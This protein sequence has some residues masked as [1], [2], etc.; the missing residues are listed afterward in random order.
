MVETQPEHQDDTLGIR[1]KIA[2]TGAFTTVVLL[3]IAVTVGFWLMVAAARGSQLDLLNEQLD[4]FESRLAEED[5]LVVSRQGDSRIRVVKDGQ[6]IPPEQP[7][8]IR[9]VRASD[10]PGVDRVIGEVNTTRVDS[11]FAT[12]RVWLWIFVLVTSLIVGGIAWLVV[13]RALRPVKQLTKQAKNNL[14]S[15]TMDLV[16]TSGTGGEIA[17]LAHTFNTMF[18]QLRDADLERRRFVSDASH[19]LRTPL[20][21]L[22][23]DAEYALDHQ[24]EHL[25][26]ENANLAQS[27]IRQSD[28]LTELVDDL[29][30][31]AVLDEDQLSLPQA[32]VQAVLESAGLT[33]LA[34]PGQQVWSEIE[35]PDIART[36]ANVA[37]N[38]R[39]HG[40][41][42]VRLV[43]RS[44]PDDVSFV[45]DDD[46]PGVPLEER[47][48]IFSRFYRSD[49]GRSRQDGGSGLGLAIAKAEVCATGGSI[50]VSNSPI[51]GA[52]FTILVPVLSPAAE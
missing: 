13:D 31:L 35:I 15:G 48:R 6:P 9:V 42:E 12:V 22:S 18:V 41:D 7:N 36:L 8:A 21:V 34:A 47:E 43:V 19:E 10:V 50:A 32:S 45:F 44:G 24:Q 30:T 52:R 51:G 29:L 33:S 3:S 2:G 4:A 16:S 11:T 5:S 25:D 40:K 27:V 39:R 38:A 28:R 49:K 14:S 26:K 23:A 20:M 1:V 17:E 46:G 37:A